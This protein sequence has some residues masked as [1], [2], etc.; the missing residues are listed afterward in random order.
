MVV[1]EIRKNM[2]CGDSAN[3]H[4][5]IELQTYLQLVMSANFKRISNSNRGLVIGARFQ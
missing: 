1:A 5:K 3:A 4:G 2:T